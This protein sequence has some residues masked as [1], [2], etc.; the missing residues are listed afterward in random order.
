MESHKV[1]EA[2]SQFTKNHNMLSVDIFHDLALLAEAYECVIKTNKPSALFFDLD[3]HNSKLFRGVGN[4]A[5]HLFG[6]ALKKNT[7]SLEF[8]TRKTM[9]NNSFD[10]LPVLSNPELA[11]SK[12][13]DFTNKEPRAEKTKYQWVKIDVVAENY[14]VLIA[15]QNRFLDEFSLTRFRPSTVEQSYVEFDKK[16]S[17]L[18]SLAT[19]VNLINS[20]PKYPRKREVVTDVYERNPYVVAKS[21]QRAN[22]NCEDCSQPAPFLRKSDSTPY[23]EVHHIIP[24]SQGGEDTLSNVIALCPNCHRKVHFGM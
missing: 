19:S 17:E 14:D 16:V 12:F 10:G 13:H 2:I 7:V 23:L 1:F 3:E 9:A 20:Y 11:F 4:S 24:L 6:F 22:G 18:A 5:L 15:I 8:T 21:L